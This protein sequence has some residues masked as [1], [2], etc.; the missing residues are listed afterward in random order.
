MLRKIFDSIGAE[1]QGISWP[2]F[3]AHFRGWLIHPLMS[4]GL[5]A[6]AVVQR[7][8]EV[9]I[10]FFSPPQASIRAHLVRHL[11]RTIDEFGFAETLV[12]IG[13]EKSMRLCERLG[14]V[15]VETRGRSIF[16]RCTQFEYARQK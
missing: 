7:G 2:S 14:F 3:R 4:G 6:G 13:N 8:P 10:V 16:M 12:E 11:Q 15:P 1:R 5:K 9:H